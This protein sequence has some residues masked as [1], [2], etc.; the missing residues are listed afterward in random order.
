MKKYEP[1]EKFILRVMTSIAEYEEMK[2]R[3]LRVFERIYYSRL[4]RFT[5]AAA[6]MAVAASNLVRL[7]M[8][9]FSPGSCG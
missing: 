5:V 8:M 9:F 1:S 3:E 4:L 7:Y 6:G 2:Q